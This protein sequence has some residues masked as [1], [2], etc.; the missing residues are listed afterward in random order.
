VIVLILLLLALIEMGICRW[1]GRR[2]ERRDTEYTLWP[3][4]G[5]HKLWPPI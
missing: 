5:G 4:E 1:L 3:E 2:S